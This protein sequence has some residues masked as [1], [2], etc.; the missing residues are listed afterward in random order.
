MPYSEDIFYRQYENDLNRKCLPVILLQSSGGSHLSWPGEIRRREGHCVIALDLPGHGKT[1]STVCHSIQAMVFSLRRFMLNLKIP[2][3]ILVGYSLGAVLALHYAANY[4]EEIK[5]LFLLSCGAQFTL[6]HSI[7]DKLRSPGSMDQVVEI[8]NPLFFDP[9]FPQK[10][11]REI[12][13]P[14]L[15]LRKSTLLA[16]LAIC[17]NY[18]WN[19]SFDRVTC[20]TRLV[21]GE[22]D[23]ITQ[24]ASVRQ[25]TYC[26]PAAQNR[27]VTRCG[28]L[29]MHE[30]IEIVAQMMGKFLTDFAEP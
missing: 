17:A 8:I 19:S 20:P 5:G 26:L 13:R 24:P 28:H 16:D 27:I 7:F 22:N 9:R 3:A 21:A 23:Q 18:S 6:P 14:M 10:Q 29:L 12:L 25:L 2:K 1:T 30:N 4:P 11:R 15:S